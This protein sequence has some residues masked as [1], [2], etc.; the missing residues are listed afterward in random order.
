M[1]KTD[2]AGEAP[3]RNGALVP[4][5]ILLASTLTFA[6][7]LGAYMRLPLVPLFAQK[8]GASTFHVGLIHA[9]FMLAA[10]LLSV[11]LGLV[12]DRLPPRRPFPWEGRRALAWAARSRAEDS[13]PRSSCRQSSSRP[14]SCWGGRACRPLPLLSAFHRGTSWR[15]SGR[16]RGTVP[17]SPA[18]RPRSSPPPRGDPFSPSFLCTPGTPGSPSPTRG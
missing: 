9:G 7:C 12:S 16:S 8:L 3:A 15:T 11:P 10:T 4:V 5:P 14:G 2:T 6:L 17:S 1:P 18:G 13:G